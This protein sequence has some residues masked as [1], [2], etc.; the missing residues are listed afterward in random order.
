MRSGHLRF[1]SYIS[2]TSI[3]G[4]VVRELQWL[5]SEEVHDHGFSGGEVRVQFFIEC[6][7]KLNLVSVT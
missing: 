5:G 1:I 7:L 4:L 2:N 3:R 6:A